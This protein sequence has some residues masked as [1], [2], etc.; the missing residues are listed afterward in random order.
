MTPNMAATTSRTS[1][2]DTD[3]M[4]DKENDDDDEDDTITRASTTMTAGTTVRRP[5]PCWSFS[6]VAGPHPYHPH[7]QPWSAVKSAS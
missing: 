1:D 4:E 3:N 2:A 5:L 7:Y 6:L